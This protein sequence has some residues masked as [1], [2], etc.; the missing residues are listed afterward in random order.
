VAAL[1][2]LAFGGWNMGTSPLEAELARG[3]YYFGPSD[4]L[5]GSGKPQL[6]DMKFHVSL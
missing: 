3:D 5:I 2:E 4:S 6:S 1:H